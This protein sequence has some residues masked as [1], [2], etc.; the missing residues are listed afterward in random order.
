MRRRLLL[1]GAALAVA[2][3]AG[4]ADL[5]APNMNVVSPTLVTAGQ[6]TAAALASLGAQG[7]G[8][9]IFFPP[10]AGR[11]VLKEEAEI[12][13]R[14]GIT[15]VTLKIDFEQPAERDYD[16]FAAAMAAQAG[17]KVLVHCQINLQASSMVFLHRVIVGKED[18]DTAYQPVAR[19]WSPPA[20]WKRFIAGTLRSHGVSFEPY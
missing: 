12:L 14:Q 10:P 18:P 17:K 19:L 5:A 13:A 16:A 15:F 20:A 11:G 1:A 6:P 3:G 2:T 4:A 9:V 8:A 7:F